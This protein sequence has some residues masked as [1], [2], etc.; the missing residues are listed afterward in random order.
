M[1]IKIE[2]ELYY[3]VLGKHLWD[4]IEFNNIIILID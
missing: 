3:Y 4:V 1:F 2:T